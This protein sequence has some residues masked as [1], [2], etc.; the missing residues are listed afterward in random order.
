M[1]NYRRFPTV[2]SEK[3][4]SMIQLSLFLQRTVETT[5]HCNISRICIKNRRETFERVVTSVSYIS[6]NLNFHIPY[7]MLMDF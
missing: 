7:K 3:T 4:V 5:V 6:L 1:R 2:S